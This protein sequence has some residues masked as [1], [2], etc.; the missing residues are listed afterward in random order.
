MKVRQFKNTY[1]N[2]N[3]Q[4]EEI[5]KVRKRVSIE[6]SMSIKDS[7]KMTIKG[8]LF[9]FVLIAFDY[10]GRNPESEGVLNII[11]NI[12]LIVS[13]IGVFLIPYGLYNFIKALTFKDDK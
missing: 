2:K 6:P 8:I 4:N 9:V 10:A 12:G 3:V 11:F 13:I 7:L 1:E 5:N